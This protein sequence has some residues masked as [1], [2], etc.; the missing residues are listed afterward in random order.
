MS[1][2]ITLKVPTALSVRTIKMN[3]ADRV[4]E[5]VELFSQS[6]Q[7]IYGYIR[8]LIPNRADAEDVFQE[9]SKVLW[10]KYGEYRSGTDFCAWAISV[11]HF[12]ALQARRRKGTSPYSF[13][14]QLDGLLEGAAIEA[15]PSSSAR[16][17]ALADCFQKLPP[18]DRDLIDAR[19]QAGANTKTLADQSRRSSD[20]I[21]RALR[22]IH[23]ALFDCVR[24]TLSE[25]G[26]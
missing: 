9:T 7:R 18:A 16:L 2:P 24:Q 23:K 26:A 1:E 20:A 17:Q 8:T 3:T 19:Y 13:S 14:E 21:Y 4:P 15:A 5:F 12:K 10:E 11:A 6:A 22:R 25:E